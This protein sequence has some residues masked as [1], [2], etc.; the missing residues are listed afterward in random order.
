MTVEP[1]LPFG[2]VVFWHIDWC[3]E[4]SI[5]MCILFLKCSQYHLIF[6]G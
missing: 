6:L 5:Y 3:V 4:L 1:I 2:V